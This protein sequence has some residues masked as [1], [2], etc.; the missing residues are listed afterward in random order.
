M[1]VGVYAEHKEEIDLV[2][3]D[4][5]MPEMAGG[6]V[7]DRIREINP[8]ARALLSSGYGLD[9]RVTDILDRGCSGFI[10]KPFD[11]KDLSERIR[12]VLEGA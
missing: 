5:I 9:G 12:E 11:L 8:H 2:I 4:M 10:Q 1:A 7:Y 6:E 3:L